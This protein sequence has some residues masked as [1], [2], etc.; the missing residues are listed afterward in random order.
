[1]WPNKKKI[2][3]KAFTVEWKEILKINKMLLSHS[4]LSLHARRRV[5]GRA[6]VREKTG[7]IDKLQK[8]GSACSCMDCS[9]RVVD[10]CVL[11][12]KTANIA[13][14]VGIDDTTYYIFKVINIF[15]KLHNT[16]SSRRRKKIERKSVTSFAVIA[17]MNHR[18]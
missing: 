15:F 4:I 3:I 2:S 10:M 16:H 18:S 8:A 5:D 7:K 17:D 13:S 12:K 1:M 11:A 9:A 14:G 6:R